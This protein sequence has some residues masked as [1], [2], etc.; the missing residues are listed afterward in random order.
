M[1]TTVKE[2]GQILSQTPGS[3]VQKMKTLLA[4]HMDNWYLIDADLM[5]DLLDDHRITAEDLLEALN[6]IAEFDAENVDF[7]H[8]VMAMKLMLKDRQTAKVAAKVVDEDFF[9]DEETNDSYTVI[10]FY[11]GH[12]GFDGMRLAS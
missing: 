3:K 8:A 2:Y 9:G 5:I 12:G 11:N 4:N 10:P 7:K 6:G 1:N